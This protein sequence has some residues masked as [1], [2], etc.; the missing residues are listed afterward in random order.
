[1][2]GTNSEWIRY[3]L[4]S[5]NDAPNANSNTI[6]DPR[7]MLLPFGNPKTIVTDELDEMEEERYEPK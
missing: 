2:S 5:G 3:I 4:T 7:Q 6:V 1:M